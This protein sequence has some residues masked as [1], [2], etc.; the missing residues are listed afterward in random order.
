MA[1]SSSLTVWLIAASA[2]AASACG[3]GGGK[4]DGGDGGGL[5]NCG[6]VQPCGGDVVGT[7]VY[8]AVCPNVAAYSAQAAANCP[9]ASVLSIDQ[10][11]SGSLTFNADLT[12]TFEV[13]TQT[14]AATSVLPLSCQPIT[15]CADL[16]KHESNAM[17]TVDSS[18]T[19]TTTCT[20]EST[21]T[22]AAQTLSGTYAVI[23]TTLSLTA[24]TVTLTNGFC[25][26][27][28]R[29]HQVTLATTGSAGTVLTDVVAERLTR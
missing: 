28:A 2:L 18:C 10:S 12:F 24:G 16:D 14:Y 1:T 13:G 6:Q 27:G 8:R 29:L 15:A 17:Q 5:D 11:Q 26:E 25:V 4:T 22:S 20:C 7:W 19:G 21:V 3:S 23:G 9:G